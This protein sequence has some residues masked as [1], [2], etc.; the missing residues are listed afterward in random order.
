M[1]SSVVTDSLIECAWVG[2]GSR[3]EKT[4]MPLLPGWR[5]WGCVQEL[6]QK[7]GATACCQDLMKI[8]AV[9]FW[10]FESKKLPKPMAGR[11]ED[12]LIFWLKPSRGN[13]EDGRANYH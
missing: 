8:T 6:G 2:A 4:T 3:R 5:R 7:G 1:P 13:Q 9:F 12:I 10:V 11:P